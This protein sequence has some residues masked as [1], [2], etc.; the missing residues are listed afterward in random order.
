MLTDQDKSRIRDEEVYREEVRKSLEPPRSRAAGVLAFL[1]TSFGMWLLSS[2]VLAGVVAGYTHVAERA[3]RA[4]ERRTR[5]EKLD[6]EIE[7]RLSQFIGFA[8]Q[9]SKQ[10]AGKDELKQRWLLAKG[11]PS[12]LKGL[13]CIHPEFADRNLVSLMV[14]LRSLVDTDGE[15]SAIRWATACVH[16]DTIFAPDGADDVKQVMRALHEKV[17]LPRWRTIAPYTDC[18]P[19]SPFC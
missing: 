1:N 6:F 15:R 4:E 7:W 19:A 13:V 8:E 17:L 3:R 5:V 9:V 12:A 18:A 14:E 16:A 2:V 11:P 10:Q